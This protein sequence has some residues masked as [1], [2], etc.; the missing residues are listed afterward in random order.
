MRWYDVLSVVLVLAE[1]LVH[2]WA[3]AQRPARQDFQYESGWGH[4]GIALGFSTNRYLVLRSS[5][6]FFDDSV[7]AVEPLMR[8]GAHLGILADLRLLPRVHL[9][10]TPTVSLADKALSYELVD[11]RIVTKTVQSTYL[12]FPL[13]LT[14]HSL[15]YGVFRMYL[16]GGVTPGWDLLSSAKARR[17]EGLVRVHSFDIGA[18]VGMGFEFFTGTFKLGVELRWHRGLRDVYV[19]SSESP[20]TRVVERLYN[21]SFFVSI[22]FE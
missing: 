20:Y 11:D 7:M 4:F 18:E 9:R 15:P 19:K 5:A 2:R 12:Y 3:V 17:V 22:M 16:L 21:R 10:F 8:L 13:H 14:L 1:V 6:I